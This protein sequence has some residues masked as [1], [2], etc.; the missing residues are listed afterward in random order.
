MKTGRISGLLL[1]P[2]SLKLS[3]RSW[4][5]VTTR[6]FFHRSVENLAAM[7][8]DVLFIV[9]TK[10]SASPWVEYKVTRSFSSATNNDDIIMHFAGTQKPFQNNCWYAL[11]LS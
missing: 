8:P 6:V 7:R 5:L 1:G 11:T 2:R 10:D 4:Y 9:H 3:Q